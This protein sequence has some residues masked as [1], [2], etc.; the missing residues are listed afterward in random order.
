MTQAWI[1]FGAGFLAGGLALS[2]AWGL[3]WLVVSLVGLARH[4][5]GWR[6][7]LNSLT[8]GVVPLGLM[9]ILVW[10]I[11][12]ARPLAPSFGVGLAGMPVLLLGL[13]LRS[14]PDGQRAGA[15]MLDGVRRLM[16]D[17][18]GKHQGCG[19]CGH[20]HDHGGCG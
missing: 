16:D 3:F 15:H 8:V 2:A 10:W 1:D 11:G 13:G 17:L 4:T 19:G 6:I 7:V 5:C 18:L 14:A 9:G 12:G 20:E